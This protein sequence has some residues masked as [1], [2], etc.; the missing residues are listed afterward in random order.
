MALNFL[1]FFLL[2]FTALG[3]SRLFFTP[4]LL[5]TPQNEQQAGPLTMGL[6]SDATAAPSIS[7]SG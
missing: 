7:R 2:I 1:A 3:T 5:N 4:F 6:P